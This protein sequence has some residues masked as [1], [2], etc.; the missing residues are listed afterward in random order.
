LITQALSI[1]GKI[2][3]LGVGSNMLKDKVINRGLNNSKIS[4]LSFGPAKVDN[5]RLAFNMR[6]FLPVEPSMGGIEPCPGSSI[7]GALMEMPAAEYQKLWLSEG[8][9]M[10][11]PGYE[12][13][14]V[15]ATP[16]GSSVTVQAVALRAAPHARLA[17]DAPPSA[18]YLGLIT[19]GAIELG[20][21]PAY[22]ERLRAVRVAVVPQYL[23][24]LSAKHSV[25]VAW[26]YRTKRLR[27]LT[28]WLRALLWFV[29][30]H[31]EVDAMGSHPASAAAA[32]A[33]ATD[34]V[35]DAR[36]MPAKSRLGPRRRP[37]SFNGFLDAASRAATCAV[38][39]P[40]AAVGWCIE[41]AYKM[42]GLAPPSPFGSPPAQ[43]RE[44]LPSAVAPS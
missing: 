28:A 24:A 21:E 36:P 2:F 29:Y 1:N 10:E 35:G 8:G 31:R 12:E 32:S 40:T 9:G 25:C 18:R 16:Y 13:I 4:V 38:I 22:L 27:F 42:R 44:Q 23:K 15:D 5:Y 6:G 3:Y 14:I 17:R 34:D 33:P 30:H 19:K 20:I 11:K 26:L 39:L 37:P 7:H 43:K 41:A